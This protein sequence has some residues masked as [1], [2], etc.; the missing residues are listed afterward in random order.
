VVRAPS[1]RI[2]RAVWVHA[3]FLRPAAVPS[4]CARYAQ[5]LEPLGVAVEGAPRVVAGETAEA[6]AGEWL[7]AWAPA[8]APVA[9]CPGAL[10]RT[11][12]WPEDRW[13]ELDA[14][15]A[16]DGRPR[17]VFATPAERRALPALAARIDADPA[18]RWVT[19]PL[20][21][22]AALLSHCAAAVTHDSGLMHLAAARGVR[23]VALFGSTSP[24]LGF[25]PA[26][27]GHIVLC[28]EEP[29]QPCTLHGRETCPR[30]HFR[31]MTGITASE[32]VAALAAIAGR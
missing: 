29:C 31:C 14:R 32:V 26:G 15:V 13:C 24:V 10:H 6:W 19:E 1:Y 11:K 9:L 28:R 16:A 2:R 7:S 17:L 5:A 12:Q 23:V 22:V 25:A 4:A 21:R 18:A 8:G 20:P 27:E 30:K 3:R